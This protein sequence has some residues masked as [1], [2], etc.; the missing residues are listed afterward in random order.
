MIAWTSD[1][2]EVVGLSVQEGTNDLVWQVALSS[3]AWDNPGLSSPIT[4]GQV[5]ARA[6]QTVPEGSAAPPALV[7]GREYAVNVGTR[8]GS[9]GSYYS[10]RVTF[11]QP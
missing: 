7:S 4:Y 5:P 3:M 11:V 8:G 9:V 2:C 1:G 6:T 10:W